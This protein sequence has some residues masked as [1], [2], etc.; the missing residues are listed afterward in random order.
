MT[1][2]TQKI[3][4]LLSYADTQLGT[5]LQMTYN[6]LEGNAPLSDCEIIADYYAQAE[7]DTNRALFMLFNAQRN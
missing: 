3:S 2:D 6:V 4:E 1:N 7:K 5:A